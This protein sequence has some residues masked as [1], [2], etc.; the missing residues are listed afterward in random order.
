[1]HTCRT[2][3]VVAAAMLSPV[4]LSSA[5]VG[6]GA[7]DAPMAYAPPP[8]AYAPPPVYPLPPPMP[9]YMWSGLYVGA[10]VGAGFADV[11]FGSTGSGF[12][13]GGQIGY[14]YQ[15]GH[16]VLG[17]EAEIS[18]SGVSNGFTSVGPFSAS[19]NWNSLT[20]LTPRIGWAFNDWLVY[21]KVGGAWADVDVTATEFGIPFATNGGIASGLVLGV[22]IEHALWI[23]NWTAKLEYQNIGFGNDAGTFATN[24]GVTFQSIKFGVNYRFGG[25][26]WF[27]P[28]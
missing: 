5:I 16:L 17:L 10:H 27:A 25:P 4:M 2:V 6:A 9:F 12:I 18:G 1:M 20:T 7:G 14:N 26:G 21:G 23:P 3:T 13:G 11:G 19:V 8:L 24:N 22:G 15:F 28:F